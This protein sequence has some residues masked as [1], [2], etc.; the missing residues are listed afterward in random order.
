MDASFSSF[1]EQIHLYVEG[2]LPDYAETTLFAELSTNAELRAEL[3]GQIHLLSAAKYHA[4]SIHA[5]PSAKNALFAELGLALPELASSVETAPVLVPVR[6]S[7]MGVIQRHPRL[8]ALVSG[9]CAS[10]LTAFVMKNSIQEK[11]QETRFQLA[12][13][14]S[15]QGLSAHKHNGSDLFLL[16]FRTN[17]L[18]ASP[19]GLALLPS[20]GFVVRPTGLRMEGNSPDGTAPSLFS[21]PTRRAAVETSL[22]TNEESS[23]QDQ[24]GT[25]AVTTTTNAEEVIQATNTS[26]T[27]NNELFNVSEELYPETLFH[28]QQQALPSS[29]APS[30]LETLPVRLTLRH[31]LS[32][33]ETGIHLGIQ[34]AFNKEHT[35]GFEGGS[36]S[37]AMFMRPS[38]TLGEGQR[39]NASD[40]ATFSGTAYYRYSFAGLAFPHT[41][42]IVP[43]AQ[44]GFGVIGRC[45]ALQGLVGLRFD[46]LP[47]L[48]FTMSAEAK[49]PVLYS[50]NYFQSKTALS[51]G[52]QYHIS[53]K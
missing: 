8:F 38:G 17:T 46:V 26:N 35:V 39:L 1:R 32:A 47:E 11:T 9:I 7:V 36:E 29:P 3:S 5:T 28:K 49:I 50:V 42:Q 20:G 34:Y 21:H 44:A 52:M 37:A 45:G 6:S 30:N 12:F 51:V 18:P 16:G 15:L 53:D 14:Q 10:L 48:S 23:N 41:K 27:S 2:L 19:S 13:E 25:F 31:V 33:K 43:F 24:F 22:S 4:A 40:D